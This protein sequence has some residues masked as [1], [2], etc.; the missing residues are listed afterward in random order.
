MDTPETQVLDTA[1]VVSAPANFL[2]GGN[3]AVAPKPTAGATTEPAATAEP[4]ETPKPEANP[5]DPKPDTQKAEA[6][7]VDPYEA[8]ALA[9]LEGSP[10]E[11]PWSDEAKAA[12]KSRFGV[13]DPIEIETRLNEAGLIKQEYDALL[14][15]K[16]G[17]EGLPPA[18]K[19]A[20]SLAL[21]GK[22]EE[23]LKYLKELPDGV[24]MD[25]EAKHIPSDKLIPM[26]LDG[27]MSKEDFDIL[28]NPSDYDDDVVAAVKLK[29]KHFRDI[30]ADM[31]ER[32]LGEVRNAQVEA[33]AAQKAA[34]EQYN[35]SVAETI[36]HAKNTPLGVFAT[37]EF[38][39]EIHTGSFV[40]RFLKEDGVTP[41]PEGATLL[42]KA[43]NYD[44]MVKAQYNV[45][46][47]RGK[48]EGTLDVANGKPGVPPVAG[49]S[50]AAPS[51]AELSPAERI[52]ANL[53]KSR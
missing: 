48:S 26:Y 16:Q 44:N 47:K 28:K 18:V 36:A 30:A 21:S 24:F 41:T 45:G 14:P 5:E 52:L 34:Y 25:K 19:N 22:P 42:L 43:L 15:I 53:G 11:T 9:S 40:R 12:L 31:H 51:T 39:Q 20:F 35:K 7:T 13:E 49:R 17:I 8:A 29:E 10:K 32:K 6:E 3:T 2:P 1:E 23:A 46:Y 27:K 33:Q 37:K 50:T 4:A 38:E